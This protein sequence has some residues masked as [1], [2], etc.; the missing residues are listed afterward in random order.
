MRRTDRAGG[1]GPAGGFHIAIVG[2]GIS[3]ICMGIQLKRAGIHNFTIYEKDPALGGTWRDNTYPGCGGDVPSFLYAF[4]F[5]SKHDWSRRFPS[6]RE[7]LG[8]LH[9]CVQKY[10]LKPH[11]SF[12]SQIISARFLASDGVW[13]IR[14]ARGDEMRANVLVSGCGQLNRPRY[15]HIDGLGAYRGACFH[16]ARWDHGHDLKGKRVAV[17]GSGASAAQ[18]VPE[19]AQKVARLSVFQRS[20]SWVVRRRDRTYKSSEL[21]WLRWLPIA[22]R[23]YRWLIYLELESHWPAFSLGTRFAKRLGEVLAEDMRARVPDRA[24]QRCLIPDYPVGCKRILVSDDYLE[25]LQAKNV[26]VV[27]NP[28]ARVTRGGIQTRDGKSRRFDTIILATGFESTRFLLDIEVEGKDERRLADCWRDGAEAYLG[29]TVAGFPNFFMCYG[30]NTNLGHN[31]SLFMIECQVRYIIRCIVALRKRRLRYLDV[32]A[33]AVADYNRALQRDMQRRVW[34]ANCTSSY[35][36]DD[37][38]VTNNWAYSSLYYWWKTKRPDFAK[39]LQVGFTEVDVSV[40]HVDLTKRPAR[41][42]RRV[43]P[44]ETE[45]AAEVPP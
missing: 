25:A 13:E 37:G 27:T 17:I 3:G 11:I 41:P 5:E 23:L 7:I 8:Y 43:A 18:L 21:R 10:G 22:R 4:S 36:T 32:R 38:K 2:A 45:T 19:I 20:P 12:G 42:P 33:D 31:S 26:D 35:K 29:V 30:P 24:L 9:A 39:F 1:W 44:G 16:S 40:P 28:I 15:P 34:V 6:Q 14:S